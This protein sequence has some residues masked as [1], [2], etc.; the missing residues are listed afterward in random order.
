MHLDL[1]RID[2]NLLV[3]FDALM[4]D[5]S[6]TAAA[7]RLSIGQPAMS[8]TLA[9]LRR[10]LNDPVLVRDGRTMVATP[11]AESLVIPVGEVL[12]QVRE[13]LWARKPF[14][15]EREQRTFRVMTSEYAAIALVHPLMVALRTEAPNIRLS[16]HT[17]SPDFAHQLRHNQLDLVIVPSRIFPQQSFS[18]QELYKERYVLAVDGSNPEIGEEISIEQFSA[19]PYLA[20]QWGSEPSLVDAELD[21]LGIPRQI[22]VTTGFGLA[23]LILSGTLLITLIPELLARRIAAMADIRLLEPPMCLEPVTETMT[24][25]PMFDDEPGLLWL[26][27]R[28]RAEALKLDGQASK[29]QT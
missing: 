18:R 14:A 19:M 22:E 21:R 25:N 29:S 24:W 20:T 7:Q 4:T 12:V 17:M 1:A 15:P 23:P 10:L 9:R 3:A 26:R 27:N 13:M 2:L 16:I 28:L 11:L 8:S 5:R 6:V